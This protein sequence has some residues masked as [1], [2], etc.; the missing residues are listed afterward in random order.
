MPSVKA[1][2]RDYDLL[3]VGDI[4]A[5]VILRG[6]DLEP[7][8][9]Q[10]EKLVS[11][12]ALTVGGSS[13]IL[14]CGAAR[15]GLRTAL[16]GVVGNDALGMLMRALLESHDVDFSGCL[17]DPAGATGVSVILIPTT[18]DGRAILTVT[19]TVGDLAA[20]D[21][22]R[23]MV[24]RSRHVH[25]G[26]Y[27]LQPRLRAG[28]T[29]LFREAREEGA[30]CSVDTNWDP[31]GRWDHGL[32]DLLQECDLFFPNEAEAKSISGQTDVDAA[33]AWLVT[34]GPAVAMK[35][36]AAG[37][38]FRDRDHSLHGK[39]PAVA[40]VDTVGAGDSFDAGYLFGH[41][42]G[43]SSERCLALALACGSLSVQGVGGTGAQPSL[44]QAQTLA[45]SIAVSRTALGVNA[46]DV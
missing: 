21:V 5:D 7:N 24:R 4:N 3:V 41:V 25:C 37:A 16:V 14:A 30:T 12:G 43:W 35:L 17:V 45:A 15:L 46:R 18:G 44:E 27:F 20:D 13:A 23:G 22:P 38:V 10:V 40:V 36:G 32:A 19:G 8:F 29:A 1:G 39:A 2:A 34:T 33:A 42:R 6:D 28:L 9:G 11:F 26:A 31:T